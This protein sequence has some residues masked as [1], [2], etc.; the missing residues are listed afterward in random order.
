MLN[1]IYQVMDYYKADKVVFDDVTINIV[2]QLNNREY[3]IVSVE[4]PIVS[5][6]NGVPN[7]CIV[8]VVNPTTNEEYSGIEI[9]EDDWDKKVLSSVYKYIYGKLKK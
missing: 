2:N 7:Y 5:G 1:S 6:F 8:H 4:K 9:T 3:T